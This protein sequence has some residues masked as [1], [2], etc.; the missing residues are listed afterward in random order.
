MDYEKF[1]AVAKDL[2]LSTMETLKL[3]ENA[4]RFEQKKHVSSTNVRRKIFEIKWSFASPQTIGR[5]TR[6]NYGAGARWRLA[7][8][9]TT[10]G[11]RLSTVKTEDGELYRRRKDQLRYRFE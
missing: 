6:K 11:A 5:K 3:S 9:Q 1:M 2:D 8:I 10:R 4:A 7:V